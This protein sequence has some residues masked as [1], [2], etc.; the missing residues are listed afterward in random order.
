MRKRYCLVCALF[1]CGTAALL[2][3]NS[4][5]S[6]AQESH[7]AG[8]DL[9]NETE[10]APYEVIAQ[11][12]FFRPTETAVPDGGSLPVA[13]LSK[14]TAS[15]PA[16]L[17]LTGVVALPA[18]PKA[19]IESSRGGSGFYVGIG[20]SVEEFRVLTIEPERVVLDKNGA[21]LEILLQKPAATAADQSPAATV[22][23]AP[24]KTPAPSDAGRMPTMHNVRMGKGDN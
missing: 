23:P 8:P 2:L 9:T 21:L 7:Q 18:G 6:L 17:I 5:S 16:S 20:D 15:T 1:L 13:A 24:V 19:I 3:N 22:T 14:P 12:N 4:A 10:L 11:R